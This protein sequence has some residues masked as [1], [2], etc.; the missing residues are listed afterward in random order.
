M[1]LIATMIGDL[2]FPVKGEVVAGDFFMTPLALEMRWAMIKAFLMR[3]RAMR[4]RGR[5]SKGATTRF[6]LDEGY[7]IGSA[8]SRTRPTPCPADGSRLR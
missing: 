7:E 3:K 2:N 5:S 4:V 1:N 8:V 6:L